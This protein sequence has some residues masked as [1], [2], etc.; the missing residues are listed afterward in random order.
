MNLIEDDIEESLQAVLERSTDD[1]GITLSS[2]K[3]SEGVI[4]NLHQLIKDLHK[5]NI[6][7]LARQAEENGE[8]ASTI[9]EDPYIHLKRLA[10]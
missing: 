5:G 8:D 10:I 1:F 2:N 9:V 3:V 7:I 6:D 4:D